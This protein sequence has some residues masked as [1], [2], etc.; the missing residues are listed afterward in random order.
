MKREVKIK[1][2][3]IAKD[4]AAY[5]PEWI[6]HHL[7]FGFDEINIY[8]NNTTDNTSSLASSMQS[9]FNVHFIDGDSYFINQQKTP[10]QKVYRDAF[11]KA[12][13]EGFS[14]VMFLDID[15][16]WTPQDMETDIKQCL[17]ELNA[18]VISFEWLNK[19]EHSLFGPALE[20]TIKGEHH[21]LV[22]SLISTQFNSENINIHNILS[23][24]T[25]NVLAD[26]SPA[27][28]SKDNQS[29][30]NVGDIKPYFITHR[31]YRSEIEYVSLLGRGRPSPTH[32]ASFKDNRNGFCQ[33]TLEVK[34]V[35]LN[36]QALAIYQEKKQAFYQRYLD[37][38][39]F[40]VAHQFVR[41]RY[42]YVVQL[43]RNATL[44]DVH[45]IKK[46]FKNVDTPEV[47]RALSEYF[48][49]LV[50]YLS[51]DVTNALRDAAIALEKKNPQK[52]LML[53][54]TALNF[55]PN[56]QLIKNKIAQ[57]NKILNDNN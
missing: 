33:P 22:K 48:S 5:L 36:T 13:Q 19:F 28:F 54:E 25:I 24:N 35:S 53:M 10:Q 7:H 16:F 27:A 43:L 3:A 15:E 2:I 56:G 20:D 44:D 26:G 18:D 29:L 4:E 14:H 37:S 55:R 12:Q 41:Q 21:R 32:T 6:F 30:I 50:S 52:S 42:E 1:L 9:L 38:D 57:Y 31:M 46:V 40:E 17:G 45:T 47:N 8:V 49:N 23:E 11:L 51:N 34:T 39:H